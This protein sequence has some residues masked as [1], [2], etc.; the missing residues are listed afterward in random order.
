MTTRIAIAGVGGRM[1]RELI[2]A[3]AADPSLEVVGGTVRPDSAAATQDWATVT[4]VPISGARVATD[5]R[6]LLAGADVLIDFTAPHASVEHARACVETGRALVCGTTGLSA[7]QMDELRAASARVPVFY[8]RNMSLGISALLAALPALVRALEGY[9]V[10]VV[11]THHRHKAD[12]PS[13]TALA[14]A[15]AIADALGTDLDER[16]VYGRRGA[17]RRRAGEIGIHALRAGGNI[18]EHTIVLAHEGE[19]IRL[20]H[21]AFGR[22]AYAQGALR[23]AAFVAG[24]APGLYGMA[25]LAAQPG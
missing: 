2:A 9:D 5:P 16:A 24:R 1:G 8:A 23:A 21:R 10:E 11:E 12:A 4:G 19:E 14:L 13:G 6:E 22:R 17:A 15:E 3:A 7:P 18:G 20:T 25:D